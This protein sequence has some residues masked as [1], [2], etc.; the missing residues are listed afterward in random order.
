[1]SHVPLRT[2]CMN[3]SAYEYTWRKIPRTGG[4]VSFAC[5]K[6]SAWYP[7][8]ASTV[9]LTPGTFFLRAL[10]A[11]VPVVSLLAEPLE[12]MEVA[13]VHAKSD[14]LPEHVFETCRAGRYR[15]VV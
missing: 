1:M 13:K 3:D 5:L 12:N 15:T 4:N 11:L 14:G 2:H 8:P 7:R 10:P 9:S 6:R